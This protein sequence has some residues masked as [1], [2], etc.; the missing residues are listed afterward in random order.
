MPLAPI[1]CVR[2]ERA[3]AAWARLARRGASSASPLPARR[4]A[5]L[6]QIDGLSGRRLREALARGELAH[7]GRL[8][9]SGELKVRMVTAATPPSTPVFQA[10]LLFGTRAD[11][12]GF[13]WYDRGLGRTVR[14]DLSEDVRAVE[15]EIARRAPGQSLLTHGVSYGTIWPARAASAFF[16]VVHF[17][18]KRRAGKIVRTLADR[19]LTLALGGA[20]AGR[21]LMRFL[22]ELGIALY[23]FQRWCRKIGST[24]FEWR[25]LYMRLFVSVVLRDV[26]TY[27]AIVDILRG[28]PVIYV[29]FLGY[30]EYAHRRGPDSEMALYNLVGIDRSIARIHRAASSV[31]D[32]GYELYVFSDHGQS[33]TIPFEQVTGRDLEHFVREH[34]SAARTAL[35]GIR[36]VTGG[37]IAHLYI[38]DTRT[39]QSIDAIE[40]RWPRLVAGLIRCRA[41]GLLVGLSARGPVF[42]YR[43]I[44]YRLGDRR[45]IE[46]LAPCRALGYPLFHRHLTE[47]ARSPRAGDLILY[48]AFA[49]SGSIS[50]D[51]EFGSHG[52]VAADELDQFILHPAEIDLP[53][54][55]AVR[56]EDFYRFYGA[57]YGAP[58][59][60]ESDFETRDAA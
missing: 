8:L 5:I 36:V 52:G 19:A 2:L 11:V 49:E 57:R 50:F 41:I 29:D 1:R 58:D 26:S 31:R 14:M 47:A 53:L 15:E 30:D 4:R 23:D 9:E 42:Y 37:S 33:A 38:G 28:V 54:D 56:A 6:L 48:G 55:G 10:G 60:D 13:S 39:E 25:F 43:G 59:G 21:L 32:Y 20:I 46:P 16:N 12:P 22:L 51:F 7:L 24:R 27:G 34:A 44:R 40:R 3:M 18:H 17:V 35:D 45:A